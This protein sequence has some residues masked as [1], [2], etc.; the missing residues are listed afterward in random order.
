MS[1]TVKPITIAVLAHNEERRIETCLDS[2]PLGRA[3]CAIHVIVNG[4]SDRTAD[5]ARAIAAKT[6]NLTVHDWPEG[7]KARSWNRFVFDTLAGFSDC[8][9]FVDGDAELAPGSIDALARTLAENGLANAAS[10]LPLNGRAHE[11]YR[12]DIIAERGLFGDL[13]AVS[14]DFLARMKAAG[15]RM[16]DD[17]INDDGLICALA[18]TDLGHESDWDDKRVEPCP[19]AGF[20]CEEVRLASPHT[21]RVQYKRMINYSVRHFQNAIMRSIMR[22][23]GPAGMPRYLKDHYPEMLGGFSPRRSLM[24]W[25]FDRQALK[26][27]ADAA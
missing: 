27:M 3:D 14:G 23:P 19:D 4:S 24:W 21:M 8:H 1:E 6:D 20:F 7:G 26:R 15:I 25:W 22:G 9:V 18:K 5:L 11:K 17:L 16:P 12:A 2:L 10:G 13:Y